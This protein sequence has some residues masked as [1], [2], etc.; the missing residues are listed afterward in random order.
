[1]SN[2]RRWGSDH[3]QVERAYDGTA[4]GDPPR[5]R[6]RRHTPP[7]VPTG[8]SLCEKWGFYEGLEVPVDREWLVIG[9]GHGADV[10]LPEHRERTTH[11][12]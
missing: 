10:A 6:R 8:A 2:P 4:P 3:P 1:M 5:K 12:F 9:R 11:D 7:P